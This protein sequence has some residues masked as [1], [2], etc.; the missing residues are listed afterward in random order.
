MANFEVA[1][2]RIRTVESIPDADR[3]ELA[4]VGEYRSVVG[5][6]QFKPGDLCAYIPEGA[7]VPDLLLEQLNLTGKLAGSKKNRVKATKFKGCLS[8]GIC[9]VPRPGWTVGQDVAD[10]LGVTKWVQEIPAHLAGQVEALSE[11]LT[12]SYDIENFKKYPDYFLDGDEVV[13][14][15][16]LHG[17]LLCCIVRGGDY[18]VASKG[19]L[20]K[21][22]CFKNN[23][24]NE[25]NFYLRIV[26]GLGLAE[27][28][29]ALWGNPGDVVHVFGEGLGVQDL[30]Y[31][32][33]TDKSV[34]NFRIFDIAV[35]RQYLND[36]ELDAACTQLGVP[37]VPIIY[38]GPFS[39]AKLEEHTTG[40]ETLT[41]RGMHIRE[42]VVVRPC[43]ERKVYPIGRLQLKSVSADYLLRKGDGT[44][45]E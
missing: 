14:T 27:R 33:N 16:K 8:Q 20:K 24:A 21:G 18:F 37:R 6:G 38:R 44:E 43:L 7:L 23:E 32:V 22:L 42:G 15:E 31:G 25:G 39:R 10:E 5:K 34:G 40:L 4:V 12:F 1:V 3:I 26:K 9:M 2:T 45:Y 30:K 28:V 35:N 29:R 17:T 11:E 13:M 19:I 36:A 41:G